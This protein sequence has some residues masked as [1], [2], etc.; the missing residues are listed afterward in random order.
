MNVVRIPAPEVER[1][2]RWKVIQL[3]LAIFSE[4][5]EWLW[6][7][8]TTTY[9]SRKLEKNPEAITLLE[10]I[11]EWNRWEYG[12]RLFWSQFSEEELRIL[13]NLVDLRMFNLF[14]AWFM[15]HN[16][17]HLRLT[18]KDLGR[19]PS[20]LDLLTHYAKLVAPQMR[21]RFAPIAP[22]E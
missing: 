3:L 12:A 13:R 5:E 8:D 19:I 14:Q 16:H 4:Q 9:L 18:E 11:N 15:R 10:R 22:L 20:F 21:A 17:D 1:I 6:S 2:S 7:K